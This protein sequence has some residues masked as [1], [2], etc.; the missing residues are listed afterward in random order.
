MSEAAAVWDGEADAFDDQPDHGLADPVVRAAW[1]SLLSQA[2]PAAPARVL[3]V[4]CGTGSLAVLLAEHGYDVVGVDLAPR[5]VERAR[6][7]A[8]VHEVEMDL[9]VGDAADPPVEGVFDVVL[10]RH[11]VWALADPASVLERWLGLLAPG[12]VLV[13]VEGFW[14]T[15][16][17]IS[18]A[19]L[20]A[21]V[22]ARTGSL[23][24]RRVSDDVALWG[25]PGG[26]R[27]LRRHRCSL[28][29]G[30]A[31]SGRCAGPPRRRG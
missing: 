23:T 17:G 31:T 7:K 1:W 18:A 22:C 10:A 6:H 28:L 5:M 16:A 15:G 3:D 8:Q 4:G 29:T 12:G 9:L 30:G 19:D 27:A 2:L 20:L 13:L 11:V 26:R 14:H 24:W 25:A 21:L